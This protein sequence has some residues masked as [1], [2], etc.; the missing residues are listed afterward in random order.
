MPEYQGLPDLDDRVQP[1][2][3]TAGA[4]RHGEAEG[5]SFVLDDEE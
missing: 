4:D 3:A 1:Q 2:T 5:Y